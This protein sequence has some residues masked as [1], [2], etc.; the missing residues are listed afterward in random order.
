MDRFTGKWGPFEAEGDFDAQEQC[1]KHQIDSCMGYRLA[2]HVAARG[3]VIWGMTNFSP[4]TGGSGLV[5]HEEETGERELVHQVL[6]L[7]PPTVVR[8]EILTRETLGGMDDRTD[9]TEH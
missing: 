5:L 1:H 8:G 9:Q 4:M 6:G 2:S 3:G 7:R